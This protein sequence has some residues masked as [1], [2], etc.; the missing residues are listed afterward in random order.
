[1]VYRATFP[2][3]GAQEHDCPVLISADPHEA[4]REILQVFKC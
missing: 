2:F 3:A 4:G 1:M